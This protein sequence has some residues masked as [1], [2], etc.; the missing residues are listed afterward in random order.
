M[1]G[2]HNQAWSIYRQ[3][4]DEYFD[5]PDNDT[6]H[7]FE[8]IATGIPYI[9]S[10]K[11]MEVWYPNIFDYLE[12]V[13]V[14]CQ[15][16]PTDKSH[17]KNVLTQI[18]SS[19]GHAYWYL[20]YNKQS[21]VL[22]YN[23]WKNILEENNESLGEFFVY[24]A[25]TYFKDDPMQAK[26][27][28]EQAIV[29]LSI[30]E[31]RWSL[32]LAICYSRLGCLQKRKRFFIRCF[33]LLTYVEDLTILL[34]NHLEEV[35]ECYLYLAKCYDQADF[36]TMKTTARQFCEQALRLFL[37]VKPPTSNFREM[38]ECV[39]LLLNLQENN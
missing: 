13:C 32:E 39:E 25:H 15:E 23:R 6:Y 38:H 16:T 3:L 34:H 35:A 33:Y 24:L 29:E 28:Y 9:E 2:N 21:A 17:F 14:R 22:C 4:S 31:E 18:Y 37:N 12:Y 19:L 11:A 27:L 10:E 5:I 30:L 26:S 1:I 36:M 7:V 8:E 20:A